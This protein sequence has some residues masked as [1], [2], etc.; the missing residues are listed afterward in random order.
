LNS[1]E[2]TK[3]KINKVTNK[4]Y[5]AL[6]L[7]AMENHSD[8]VVQLMGYSKTKVNINV[9]DW[10][11]CTALMHAAKKGSLT[12]LKTLLNLKANIYAQDARDMTALHH[13]AFTCNIVMM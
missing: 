11:G 12:V 6:H 10:D 7:A 1:A 4:R 9:A 13:A 5:H 3:L 2:E 8:V